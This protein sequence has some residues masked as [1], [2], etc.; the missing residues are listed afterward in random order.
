MR[1]LRWICG[2]TRRDRIRNG[3]VLSVG[4]NGKYHQIRKIGQDG[5][6]TDNQDQQ[7]RGNKRNKFIV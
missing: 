7:A 6:F 1:M 2:M 5:L 4:N 3:N